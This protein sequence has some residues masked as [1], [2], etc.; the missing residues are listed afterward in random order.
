MEVLEYLRD[1]HS[2]SKR[3][4]ISI[5]FGGGQILVNEK[6]GTVRYRLKTEDVLSVQFPPEKIGPNL[7]ATDLP[8]D[9]LYEDEAIIILNKPAGVAVMPS[10]HNK[11]GTIANRLLAYYAKQNIPYTVHIVTR[12]DRDTSGLLLVA[13]HSY[14]HSLLARAQQA[15]QVNRKYNAIIEGILNNKHGVIDE[16]I[17]RKE[18]SIIERRVHQS[19]KTAVTEY[20]VLKETD[21][22]SLL[23]VIL[24]TGRTHQIRVH[25]SFIGHPLLGDGL[26]GGTKELMSRQALHCCELNFKHPLTTK[27]VS[28]HS[29][30]PHDMR[31]LISKN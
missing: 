28:Y 25:F 24:K 21:N 26:Y 8:L 7:T 29:P 15:G 12:L 4:I 20:E 31:L 22:Y 1:I 14:S 18:D 9:I 27:Q 13:K 3:I 10:A 19:G 11:T 5:K 6:P 17:A 16:P 2:F 30:L 23:K